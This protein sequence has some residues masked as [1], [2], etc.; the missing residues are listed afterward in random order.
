MIP[1]LLKD[2]FILLLFC[3]LVMQWKKVIDLL[4]T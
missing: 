3:N 4:N 2:Y 1:N